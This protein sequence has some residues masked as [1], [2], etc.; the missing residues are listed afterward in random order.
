MERELAKVIVHPASAEWMM[1]EAALER[2]ERQREREAERSELAD[3]WHYGGRQ[4]VEGFLCVA[5]TM[6]LV[7]GM[8]FLIIVMSPES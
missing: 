7:G 6:A 3:W 1:R 8:I 4:A 2:Q 5:L